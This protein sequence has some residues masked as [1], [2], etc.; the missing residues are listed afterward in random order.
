MD[1]VKKYKLIL[2][3]WKDAQSDADWG[4]EVKVKEWATQDYLV[5]EIGWEIFS[6]KEYTIICSQI[7]NDGSLGNRTK[8]PKKW[9][10]KKVCLKY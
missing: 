7:G 6:N 5:S 3:T 1:S 10:V 4:E 2:I 9:V 8:I